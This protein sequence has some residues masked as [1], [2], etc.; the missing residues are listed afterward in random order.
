M[1]PHYRVFYSSVMLR[2]SFS[3]L[4]LGKTWKCSYFGRIV[5]CFP[6]R[7][8]FPSKSVLSERMKV[9]AR[10]FPLYFQDIVSHLQGWQKYLTSFF[11]RCQ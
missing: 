2:I 11:L 10:G 6:E 5:K 1:P 7:I 8:V 3:G 9:F 4:G